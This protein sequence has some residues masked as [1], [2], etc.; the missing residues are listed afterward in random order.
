MSDLV[1]NQNVGFLMTRFIC[2]PVICFPVI[3]QRQ[4]SNDSSSDLDKVSINSEGSQ[5]EKTPEKSENVS[6]HTIKS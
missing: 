4:M 3:F 5:R 1:G 6:K 2:F